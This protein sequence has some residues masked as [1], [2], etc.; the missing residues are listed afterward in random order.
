I[1]AAAHPTG[2]MRLPGLSARYALPHQ[3]RALPATL[4]QPA[5]HGSH[6]CLSKR[7]PP[8]HRQG[9]SLRCAGRSDTGR[10]AHREYLHGQDGRLRFHWQSIL[11]LET[12]TP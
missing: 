8:R 12:D 7:T 1:P 9:S 4:M 11:T 2:R 6:P 10:N 5:G 3:A